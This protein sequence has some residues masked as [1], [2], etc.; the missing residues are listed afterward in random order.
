MTEVRLSIHDETVYR[1][2]FKHIHAHARSRMYVCVC[3][4]EREGGGGVGGACVNYACV[5][6]SSHMYLETTCW[7]T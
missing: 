1:V 4:R 6:A 3:V 7:Q 2:C 5:C